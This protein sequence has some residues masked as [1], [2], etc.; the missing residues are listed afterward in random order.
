MKNKIVLSTKTGFLNV[1]NELTPPKTSVCLYFFNVLIFSLNT[2]RYKGLLNCAGEHRGELCWE[3][4]DFRAERPRPLLLLFII[5]FCW[6][7]PPKKRTPKSKIKSRIISLGG[8][9]LP[10]EPILGSIKSG[11]LCRNGPQKKRTPQ[12]KIKSRIISL[13][14]ISL[15]R[16][17][18]LDSVIVWACSACSA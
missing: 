2:F 10:R 1:S 9:S 16:A 15:P 7:G 17:P 3:S 13:G 12:S 5:Y 14:G 8:I 11:L 6:N 18:I 4:A